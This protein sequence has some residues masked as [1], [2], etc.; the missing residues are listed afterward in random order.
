M[1]DFGLEAHDWR[2]ER[3]F[4]RNLNVDSEC[5]ALVGCVWRTVELAAEVCEVVA[6]ACGLDN[7]LGV[8][9]VLDVGNLLCDAPGAVGGGHCEECQ[10]WGRRESV[11]WKD[12]RAE[13]A[14]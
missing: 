2:S 5:A 7:D 12:K 4:A 1:P 10:S 11:V 6:V 3:V 8:L 9:I 13:D 14:Q